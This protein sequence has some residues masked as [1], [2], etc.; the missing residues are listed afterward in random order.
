MNKMILLSML[1]LAIYYIDYKCPHK[2]KR[3]TASC[4]DFCDYNIGDIPVRCFNVLNSCN[5]LLE[6]NK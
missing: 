4:T 1:C 5:N 6:Q 2:I 3:E